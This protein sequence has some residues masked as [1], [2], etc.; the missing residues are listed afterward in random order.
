V[1]RH[2]RRATGKAQV[3]SVA[4][5]MEGVR[6]FTG[7]VERL[8]PHLAQIEELQSQLESATELLGVMQD[9]NRTLQA[10]LIEQRAIYLH[11]FARGM[12]V[13]LDTVLSMETE[14]QNLLS[15]GDQHVI[16]TSRTNTEATAENP[17]A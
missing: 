6:E 8:Q 3:G 10:A 9:E 14:I 13:S 7:L 1:N 2:T 11:M 4:K 12:G 17:G 15:Q 5:A 16:E